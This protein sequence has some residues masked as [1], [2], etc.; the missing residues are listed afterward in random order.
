VL[1][2]VLA[3][4]LGLGLAPGSAAADPASDKTQVDELEKALDKRT[5]SAA[6]CGDALK[7]LSA[8]NAPGSLTFTQDDNIPELNAGKHAW[9]DARAACSVLVR[10]DRIR[11]FIDWASSARAEATKNREIQN[12]SYFKNC[13]STYDDAIQAGVP[14]TQPI[15][16]S[17]YAVKG[18]MQEV[19]DQLCTAGMAKLKAANDEAEAPY[20]KVLKNDKLR[21]WLRDTTYF[22]LAGVAKLTPERLAATRVWFQHGTP[23][24]VCSN[25]LGVHTLRRFQFDAQ[26]KLVKETVRD[27]CGNPPDSAWR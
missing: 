21:L 1:T 4:A 14:P 17:G 19:R 18:T 26:H 7:A 15:D 9:T 6:R 13:L 22:E 20:R 27:F 16:D 11:H 3:T 10:K 23:E 2:G 25:G 5:L 24:K 8:A 12:E